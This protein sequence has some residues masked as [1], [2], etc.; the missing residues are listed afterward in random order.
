MLGRRRGRCNAGGLALWRGCQVVYVEEDVR[1]PSWSNI[2]AAIDGDPYFAK[3]PVP[4]NETRRSAWHVV[5]VHNFC[6]VMGAN[7][8]ACERVGS[9]M[10]ALWENHRHPSIT[11]LMDAVV[12]KD[13]ALHLLG[14]PR[15]EYVIRAVGAALLSLGM[16][17]CVNNEWY[18]R[19]HGC[20]KPKDARSNAMDLALRLSEDAARNS[21]R[22]ETFALLLASD[23]EESSD[24]EDGEAS[25]KLDFFKTYS[26]L[27]EINEDM[28]MLSRK[29]RPEIHAGAEVRETCRKKFLGSRIASLPYY[30]GDVQRTPSSAHAALQKWFASK[31][32]AEWLSNRT[33]SLS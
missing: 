12:L 2:S 24:E 8:A 15:D 17:P 1:R 7:E 13:A 29:I 4:S 25:E 21:G 19:R 23:E 30:P 14:S 32:G 31:P 11:R 18:R 6:R 20:N 27:S 28:A 16:K 26:S 33:K 10:T 9:R 5:R 22:A 3:G